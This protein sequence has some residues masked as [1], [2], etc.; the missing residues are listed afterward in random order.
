MVIVPFH[1]SKELRTGML[2]K[3]LNDAELETR[4]G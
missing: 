3:I 1:G 4:K 2:R